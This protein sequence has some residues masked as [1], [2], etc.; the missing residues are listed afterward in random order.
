[1]IVGA[2]A[3]GRPHAG[4]AILRLAWGSAIALDIAFG[5]LF[6]ELDARPLWTSF[7]GYT[8]SLLPSADRLFAFHPI[9][10]NLT[11]N[12]YLVQTCHRV[13][14][15]GLWAAAALTL[16]MA[17]L[18]N[19]LWERALLLFGLLTLEGVLGVASLQP[20]QPLVLSIVHQTCA[21]AVL[22][23]ALSPRDWWAQ[24]LVQT[25]AVLGQHRRHRS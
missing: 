8:D 16:V 23:A 20:D 3:P 15:I 17:L 13:L 1:V 2:L 5:V 7:P 14:S 18:R 11:E 12:G 21:L 22:V 4:S 10:R 9:W 25:S 19:L 6:E 24:P